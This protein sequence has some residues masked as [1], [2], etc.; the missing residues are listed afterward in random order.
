MS[1]ILD[2]TLTVSRDKSKLKKFK[3]KAKAALILQI[4]TYLIQILGKIAFMNSPLRREI[5]F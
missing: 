2:K 1:Q 4:K 5:H 3:V